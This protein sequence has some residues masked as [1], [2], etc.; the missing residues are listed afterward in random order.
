MSASRSHKVHAYLFFT[1]NLRLCL[2]YS[3]DKGI[4]ST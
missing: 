2:R 3:L 1:N 4:S